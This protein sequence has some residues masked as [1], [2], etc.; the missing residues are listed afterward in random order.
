MHTHMCTQCGLALGLTVCNEA[1]EKVYQGG[2]SSRPSR[3]AVSFRQPPCLRQLPGLSVQSL[4]GMVRRSNPA[5]QRVEVWG[6][7]HWCGSCGT[8]RRTVTYSVPQKGKGGLSRSQPLSPGPCSVEP[9]QSRRCE[10]KIYVGN[11]TIIVFTRRLQ[12]S[13]HSENVSKRSSDC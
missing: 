8:P 1:L 13:K 10:T 6:R 12:N 2:W 4:G 9:P 5:E 3:P 11:F 7:L